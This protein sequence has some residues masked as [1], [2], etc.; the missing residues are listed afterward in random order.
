MK[1]LIQ[2][3]GGTSVSSERNRKLVAKKIISAIEQGYKTVVVVSA[4][5]RKGEPYATDTLLGLLSENFK[6][7]NLLATDLMVGCGEIISTAVI[8]NELYNNN[9]NAIPL[10]GGLAGIKT[11]NNYGNATITDVDTERLLKLLN[12]D[13]IP[14]VAGFQG[15]CEEGYLTTLGRGGSDVT[16]AILGAALKAEEIHIYTDVDGIMTADPR[17]VSQATLI[18]AISYDE[19]CQFAYQ[20]AKVIHPRAVEI[21][22][23]YNIPLVIKNTLSDCDG[24]F[25]TNHIEDDSQSIIT[26]ITHVKDR[27]QITAPDNN[28]DSYV[29]LF[30]IIAEKGISID[31][32]NVF[33]KQKIFTIALS[34]LDKFKEIT[35]EINLQCSYIENCSKIAIIGSK[36]R[37]MPGVMARILKTLTKE[38]IEVLQTADSHMTIWCLVEAPYT[39]SAINVLHK[40]FNL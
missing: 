37:G 33:P 4:M 40:E 17:I 18:K 8:S 1:I 24:T 32:I 26:G 29:E 25:I 15:T 34:D 12:E 21:S 22:K 14:V 11:D 19:V 31:L 36:M 30:E 6:T 13:K 5:G 28:S 39:E 27:V 16:A 2:K 20:G 38:K 23:K 9:L 7:N 10:T 3:F 35:N